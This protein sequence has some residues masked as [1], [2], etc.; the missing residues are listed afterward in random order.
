MS[1]LLIN[2]SSSCRTLQAP[3]RCSSSVYRPRKKDPTLVAVL[4]D[5]VA[6]HT[7]GDPMSGHKWL[8]CRLSDIRQQLDERG[9]LVSKPVISRLLR[10]HGYSLRANVKQDAGKQY[11]DRDQQFR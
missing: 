10:T 8:N 11:P 7:A 5:I 3:R 2:S 9:H 4:L 1:F 6:P